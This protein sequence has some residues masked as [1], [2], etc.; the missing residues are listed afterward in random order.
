MLRKVLFYPPVLNAIR[1]LVDSEPITHEIPLNKIQRI[2]L[3]NS[4]AIGDTL[5]S[6]PAIRA[7]RK[8]LPQAKIYSLASSLAKQVLLLN[9]NI[10]GII[11]CGGK[12]DLIYIFNFPFLFKLIRKHK[13]DMVMVLHAND[14]DVP[15]LAYLSKAAI[16]YGWE[17]SRLSF[18]FNIH[19]KNKF[20]GIHTVDRKLVALL[21]IGINP[22]GRSYDFVLSDYELDKIKSF[23]TKEGLNI[24]EYFTIHPFASKNYKMWPVNHAYKLCEELY[25][26][27]KM[28]GILLGGRKERNS[29]PDIK[30]PEGL[31]DAR[32]LFPVRESAALI[33]LSRFLITSDSGPMHLAQAVDTPT[34]SIIGP[35]DPNDTGPINPDSI[36]IRKDLDCIPCL[37][38]YD[39]SHI[40]CMRE[41]TADIVLP[42]L[43]PLFEK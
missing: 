13:F 1:K 36:I 35:T 26:H 19:F 15:I 25:N 20:D 27:K 2:L 32:G 24:K 10:D 22:E 33:K 42:Y 28:K 4:T 43:T 21:K 6:T 31:I 34:V 40:S 3:V 11:D 30:I 16:R 29:L 9:P 8:A 39:C 23:L 41:I 37:R 17:E 38:N 14:P 12:V 5:M 7:I 18:M